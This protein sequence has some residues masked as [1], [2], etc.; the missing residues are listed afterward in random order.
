MKKI[1]YIFKKILAIILIGLMSIFLYQ[2]FSD[3]KQDGFKEQI[4]GTK[5]SADEEIEDSNKKV[6]IIIENAAKSVVGIS[7]IRSLGSSVFTTNSSEELG[8]GSGIII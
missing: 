8:L 2:I 5:L 3:L 1:K 6:S 4:Y 7:K